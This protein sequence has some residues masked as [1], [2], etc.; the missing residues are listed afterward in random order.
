MI[1]LVIMDFGGIYTTG[2]SLVKFSL[3]L[4]NAACIG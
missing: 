1:P 4:A 2:Y 3:I